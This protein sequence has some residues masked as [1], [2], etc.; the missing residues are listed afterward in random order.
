[1][2]GF[3]AKVLAQKKQYKVAATEQLLASARVFFLRVCFWKAF[4][5]KQDLPPDD[6]R[7]PSKEDGFAGGKGSVNPGTKLGGC[8]AASASLEAARD[9]PCTTDAKDPLAATLDFRLTTL[10]FDRASLG[11]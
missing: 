6:H 7:V 8:S 3:L 1:M 2:W 4:K 10:D 11:L 5:A 9:L